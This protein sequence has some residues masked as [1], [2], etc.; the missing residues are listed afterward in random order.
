MQN[1]KKQKGS[2]ILDYFSSN[3]KNNPIS[4]AINSESNLFKTYSEYLNAKIK[5]EESYNKHL[6]NLITLD[7]INN[8]GSSL[9]TVFKDILYPNNIEGYTNYDY[10]NPLLLS[11]YLIDDETKPANF[12]REHI[13]QQIWYQIYNLSEYDNS[14]FTGVN[15]KL[16]DN[17]NV[18]VSFILLNNIQFD[19]KVSISSNYIINEKELNEHIEE[20]IMNVKSNNKLNLKKS[21][22]VNINNNFL[23][24]NETVNVPGFNNNFIKNTKKL[25]N[26]LK[27]NNK[28][29][30]ILPSK[31]SNIKPKPKNITNNNKK[32]KLLSYNN[33]FE[34][35]QKKIRGSPEKPATG[36][37]EPLTKKQILH[38]QHQQ[39]IPIEEEPDVE[40]KPIF[41]VS[42]ITNDVR[43]LLG[44]EVKK[45]QKASFYDNIPLEKLKEMDFSQLSKESL[46]KICKRFSEDEDT[47]KK[48]EQCWYNAK[49]NPKCYRF[50]GKEET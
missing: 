48:I 45:Q 11:S 1:N 46:D 17:K 33:S 27:L 25:N 44:L 15:V 31:R 36:E 8:M 37:N 28:T 6:D 14:L 50:K 3:K 9:V 16:L 13:R 26:K 38:F 43:E 19:R 41:A 34:Q 23:L 7:K 20:I 21:A 35:F 12:R 24:K 10:K 22:K 40:G 5:Y 2:G 42:D 47:C 49:S 29:G 4:I 39:V 32:K 18:M 30:K